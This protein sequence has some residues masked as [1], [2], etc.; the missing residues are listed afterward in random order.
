MNHD[1]ERADGVTATNGGGT[2]LGVAAEVGA[3]IRLWRAP[4]R[5]LPIF[6]T[7]LLARAASAGAGPKGKALG[8]GGHINVVLDGS[9]V[10]DISPTQ[11]EV[12]EVSPGE[13][14]LSVRFLGGLRRSRKLSVS[15]AKGEQQEFV[16]LLNAF[17]WPSL[18]V[19]TAEDVATM[20]RG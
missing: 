4:N 6:P 5:I 18:R 12:Y 2:S 9:K 1:S 15:I 17:A 16:C 7:L 14:S 13:H 8:S 11:T 20:N 10:G 3:T 19:A